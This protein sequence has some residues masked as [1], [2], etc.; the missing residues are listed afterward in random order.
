MFDSVVRNV[1]SHANGEGVDEEFALFLGKDGF[2]AAT[3][4]VYEEYQI[5]SKHS[6]ISKQRSAED[7]VL[8][9]L[10]VYFADNEDFDPKQK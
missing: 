7:D 6:N 4:K 5:L 9:F 2:T 1:L 3:G 8:A 10:D